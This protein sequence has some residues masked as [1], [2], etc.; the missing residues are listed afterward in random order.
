[1]V[2]PYQKGAM[3][4]PLTTE[5]KIVI[6]EKTVKKLRDDGEL[7][8]LPDQE[9]ERIAQSYEE[10]SRNRMETASLIFLYSTE[11]KKSQTTDVSRE[12]ADY[13]EKSTDERHAKDALTTSRQFIGT[14]RE[15][16]I[17]KYVHINF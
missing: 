7:K 5:Q 4:K 3:M 1:M 2:Q 13:G 6:A 8:Q 17:K 15:L 12:Y 9:R 16:M 10:R 14:I 11:M